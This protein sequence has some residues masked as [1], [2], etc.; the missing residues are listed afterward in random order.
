MK[1]TF[2]S[3]AKLLEEIH[4]YRIAVSKF[5]NNSIGKSELLIADSNLTKILSQIMESSVDGFA[6][7]TKEDV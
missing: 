6:E 1:M 7:L 5:A 4:N 2:Q 3:R